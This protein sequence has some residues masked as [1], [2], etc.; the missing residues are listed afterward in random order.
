MQL[1][2]E[3]LLK[4]VVFLAERK[5]SQLGDLA[6]VMRHASTLVTSDS[7]KEKFKLFNESTPQRSVMAK[8][9]TEGQFT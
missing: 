9:L 1:G 3:E 4:I 6:M 5:P 2:F 7:T 8:E